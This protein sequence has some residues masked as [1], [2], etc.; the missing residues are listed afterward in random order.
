MMNTHIEIQKQNLE[1]TL[2]KLEWLLSRSEQANRRYSRA[3]MEAFAILRDSFR[4]RLEEI[5][6]EAPA[7]CMD[8]RT[9]ICHA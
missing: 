8:V 1:M 5:N 3:Q 2:G 6:A 9:G 4:G 7:T